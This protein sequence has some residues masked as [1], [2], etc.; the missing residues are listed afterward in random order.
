MSDE[1]LVPE[2]NDNVRLT[3]KNIL[4]KTKQ[5][6]EA[7]KAAEQMAALHGSPGWVNGL[8]PYIE[9]RIEGL[10]GM[11]EVDLD[12]KETMTEIGIRFVICTSIAKELEYI[13]NRVENTAK[14]V[15]EA[16][17]E[18]EDGKKG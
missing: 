3:A 2:F 10:K 5:K 12:G 1:A 11:I 9:S 18:K 7:E 17:K 14:A 6:S 15:T 8:K 4:D 16:K 13:V